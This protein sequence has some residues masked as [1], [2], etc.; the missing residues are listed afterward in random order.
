MSTGATYEAAG[1]SIIP[2]AFDWSRKE[3]R[4]HA[5]VHP[6]GNLEA[7]VAAMQ[8]LFR[9]EMARHPQGFW[10]A[11]VPHADQASAIGAGRTH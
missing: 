6:S 3:I 8:A 5:P 2:V 4:I 1:V 7:D 9:P 11:R 10:K